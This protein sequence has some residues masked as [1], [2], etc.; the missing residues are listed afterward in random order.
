MGF[1]NYS[2]GEKPYS[3]YVSHAGALFHKGL[4]VRYARKST[5]GINYIVARHN[6]HTSYKVYTFLK[7]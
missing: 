2:A 7:L 5:A 3:F 6:H 1:A 4:K